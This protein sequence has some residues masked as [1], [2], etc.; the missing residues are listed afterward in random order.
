MKLSWLLKRLCDSCFVEL[1]LGDIK[2]IQTVP[3]LRS[4]IKDGYLQDFNI[5][6]EMTPDNGVIDLVIEVQI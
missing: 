4:L 5:T 6:F 3:C 1:W 2:M